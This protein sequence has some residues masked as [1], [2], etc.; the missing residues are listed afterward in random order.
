MTFKPAPIETDVSTPFDRTIGAVTAWLPR[1]M[2]SL[3]WTGAPA[4]A[5]S[6]V[7]T[8]S[9]VARPGSRL[10][11]AGLS[12]VRRPKMRSPSNVMAALPRKLLGSSAQS[13]CPPGTP[14]FQ[15]T[16]WAQLP[17]VLLVQAVGPR[18]VKLSNTAVPELPLKVA[19][20]IPTCTVSPAMSLRREAPIIVHVTPSV[21]R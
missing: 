19:C 18:S 12:M 10:Y 14:V 20:Q 16:A 6:S 3:G 17:P 15:L 11:G 21:L 5:S 2:A 4:A 8:A 9:G 7:S 13:P 1:W